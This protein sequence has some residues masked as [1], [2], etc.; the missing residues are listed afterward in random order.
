MVVVV[1]WNE[2]LGVVVER[3]KEHQVLHQIMMA[4]VVVGEVTCQLAEVEA[5]Q[6]CCC[7]W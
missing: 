7:C 5:A 4:P 2:E 1:G 3:V 6:P